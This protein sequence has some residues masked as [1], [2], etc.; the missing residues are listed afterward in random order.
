MKTNKAQTRTS[1]LY[2]NGAAD[3]N[4]SIIIHCYLPHDL[5][6]RH[7]KVKAGDETN[8]GFCTLRFT[9]YGVEFVT[10]FKGLKQT[11]AGLRAYMKAKRIVKAMHGKMPVFV[12]RLE[13]SREMKR[14]LRLTRI[15][16]STE[17]RQAI[18]G[19]YL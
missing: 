4:D 11:I 3:T 16:Q 10:S 6:A 8:F 18:T 15:A 13:G 19:F 9:H 14:Q 7:F 17:C 1:Q 2:F 5:V 12:I